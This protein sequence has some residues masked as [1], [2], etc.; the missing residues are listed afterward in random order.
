MGLPLAARTRGVLISEIREN[1]S[2]RRTVT[3]VFR[4]FRSGFATAQPRVLVLVVEVVGKRRRPFAVGMHPIMQ[5]TAGRHSAFSV[6]EGIHSAGQHTA[7]GVLL[8]AEGG[9]DG[10][11]EKKQRREEEDKQ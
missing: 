11:R 3:E 2:H 9:E 10:R 6:Q 4:K 1:K 8:T 7:I 5:C